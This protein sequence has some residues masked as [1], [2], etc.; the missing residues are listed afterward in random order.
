MTCTCMTARLIQICSF[1][2]V[3][4]LIFDL[5]SLIELCGD[6]VLERDCRHCVLMRRI[7]LVPSPSLEVLH[8]STRRPAIC[9]V[10]S[11]HT[12]VDGQD[13]D[14]QWIVSRMQAIPPSSCRMSMSMAEGL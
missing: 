11:K 4:R 13:R 2:I 14:S 6:A 9:E 12:T 5:G 8:I 1:S 10:R 3:Y 7:N